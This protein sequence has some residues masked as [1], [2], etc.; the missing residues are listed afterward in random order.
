MDEGK[1]QNKQIDDRV[2]TSLAS[3]EIDL[4]GDL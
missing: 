4:F 2:D 1:K 3:K